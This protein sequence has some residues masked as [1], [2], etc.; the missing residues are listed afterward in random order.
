MEGRSTVRRVLVLISVLALFAVIPA[1]ATAGTPGN[2]VEGP[3]VYMDNVWISTST[4]QAE[5]LTQG[6]TPPV[7]YG[8]PNDELHLLSSKNGCIDDYGLGE[9]FADVQK[10][11]EYTFEFKQTV[12]AFSLR[13]LDFGDYNPTRATSHEVV[14]TAYAADGITILGTDVLEFASSS[15]VNP[16]LAGS[17][18][19]DLWYTGDACTAA[20]GE[21]GNY[22]FSVES[23]G[24]GKVT[25]SATVGLDPNIAFTDMDYTPEDDG[26]C[27]FDEV[28]VWEDYEVTLWAGQ[29][30]DAGTVNVSYDGTN[31][32]V[33]FDADYPW[34]LSETHVAVVSDV[35]DFPTT[36]K[37]NP[38]PGKFP[39]SETHDPMIGAYTQVIPWDGG[40]PVYIAPHAALVQGSLDGDLD[41][42]V[43]W[44]TS[45]LDHNL[46]YR[47]YSDANRINPLNALYSPNWVGGDGF[48]SLGLNSASNAGLIPDGSVGDITVAFGRWVLNGDGYDISVHEVTNSRDS[49]PEETADVYGWYA[50]EWYLLGSVSNHDQYM[51]EDPGVGLVDL[52]VLPYVEKVKIVDTSQVGDFTGRV[53]DGYDVDAVDAKALYYGEETGWGEGTRF[54]DTTW[55]M[56]FMYDSSFECVWPPAPE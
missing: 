3:G 10:T 20:E 7:V 22:V 47:T 24:I 5:Y 18:V 56:Y 36:K 43:Y 17:N 30:I 15:A 6:G 28:E 29:T 9:G 26:V 16:H 55:G 46:G 1:I 38:I 53:Y 42:G 50:D 52:G 33:A 51:G 35:A 41:D 11:H 27:V 32:S 2:S 54:V 8:A 31:I 39:Y 37:G 49:Y 34:K 13:M 25:L 4:G 23:A 12:D 21:P 14:M 19:G 40:F 44:A 48:Y 45:V